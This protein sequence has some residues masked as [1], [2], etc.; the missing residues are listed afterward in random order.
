MLGSV[1][2]TPT[3]APFLFLFFSF[4]SGTYYDLSN[5]IALTIHS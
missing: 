1:L 4:L 2:I 5:F 3:M